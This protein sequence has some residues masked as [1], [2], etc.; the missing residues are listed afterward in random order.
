MTEADPVEMNV[1]EWADYWASLKVDVVQISVTGILAFYPSKVPFHKHGRFL[2]GRDFFGRRGFATT[3][4]SSGLMPPWRRQYF[5]ASSACRPGWKWLNG[6]LY[7]VFGPFR[8]APG[9]TEPWL[10]DWPGLRHL[11]QIDRRHK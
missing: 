11:G 5:V 2:K 10:Q 6:R 8:S 4:T 1:E 9:Q 7:T 3:C